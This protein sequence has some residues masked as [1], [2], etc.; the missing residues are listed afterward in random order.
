M[1]PAN[2]YA[3]VDWDASDHVGGYT[4]VHN[5]PKPV[6]EATLETWSSRSSYDV[7]ET[8]LHDGTRYSCLQAHD[9]GSAAEP[10]NGRRSGEY[11]GNTKHLRDPF[12]REPAERKGIRH[13][14]FTNHVEGAPTTYPLAEYFPEPLPSG[15]IGT[16]G[17]EHASF[18]A[19]W[20]QIANRHEQ[21]TG[22]TYR[23]L[24]AMIEAVAAEAIYPDAGGI[25]LNHSDD[26]E[27]LRR[28]MDAD[29]TYV[30]GLEVL[31]GK[32][33]LYGAHGDG[34]YRSTWDELLRE[35]PQC[36]GFGNPD[37]YA[38]P[39]ERT[40]CLSREDLYGGD[41]RNILL[42]ENHTEQAYARGYRDGRFY[43][44]RTGTLH[45]EKI[46]FSADTNRVLVVTDDAQTIRAI[47][48]NEVVRAAGPSATLTVPSDRTYLR[49]E[50]A[51][52]DDLLCSQP[53][54]N[55]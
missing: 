44:S 37:G 5:R 34:D 18:G 3:A 46:S 54:R 17:H 29:P 30:L 14:N 52:Q 55:G 23:S 49:I 13:F 25:H 22:E 40:P 11:W 41:V 9:A 10:G 48:D 36:W 51:S 47:T 31:N 7:L 26:P 21:I 16:P 6:P 15:V 45:F 28:A 53:I 35:G 43:V 38:I 2:P 19:H 20:C 42:V 50:A 24:P 39:G 12:L 4:H 8:V 27:P 32:G 1:K 33:L